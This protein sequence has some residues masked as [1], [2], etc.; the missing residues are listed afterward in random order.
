MAYLRNCVI[1]KP[2]K[3][4]LNLSIAYLPV[5]YIWT[6]CLRP[7]R[8][9][10]SQQNSIATENSSSDNKL[11]EQTRSHNLFIDANVLPS[12][13][14]YYQTISNLMHTSITIT[15]FWLILN[16][17][18]KTSSCHSY[19][20]RASASGNF[21]VNSSDVELYKLSFSRFRAK[22]WNEIPC[23]IRHPPQE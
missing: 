15:S 21:Y 7:S 2:G 16:L 9:D 18:Q 13:F 19:N 17:F 6:Y 5:Y 23:H 1:L 8:K 12:N 3:F 22:L 11:L 14:S 4:F 10:T 20:T